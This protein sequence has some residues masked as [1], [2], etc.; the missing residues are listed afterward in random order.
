[1]EKT[2]LKFGTKPI[3]SKRSKNRADSSLHWPSS[4]SVRGESL[5]SG[6]SL[7]SSTVQMQTHVSSG[8]TG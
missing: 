2:S 4:E 8:I 1:M 3:I 5:R 6:T 7:A